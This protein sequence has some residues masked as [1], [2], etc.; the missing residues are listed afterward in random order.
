MRSLWRSKRGVWK[1]GGVQSWPDATLQKYYYL[2][3]RW[4]RHPWRWEKILENIQYY[5]QDS[6]SSHETWQSAKLTHKYLKKI[7]KSAI[8]IF[9]NKVE[10]S[11]TGLF[12]LQ[13]LEETKGVIRYKN[14]A[15]A[16]MMAWTIDEINADEEILPGITLGW[17]KIC[18]E[19]TLNQ[20]PYS[21]WYIG[22]WNTDTLSK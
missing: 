20:Y 1:Q 6:E 16:E 8:L 14:V 11:F 7:N 12:P 5:F 13:R 19:T 18:N 15:L 3:K 2:Q 17:F 22:R 4:W 9:D 21:S 10:L